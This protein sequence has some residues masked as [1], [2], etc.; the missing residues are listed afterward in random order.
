MTS[1]LHIARPYAMAAFSYARDKQQLPAWKAF[2]A[3]AAI[4]SKDTRVV[5]WLTQP[6]RLK[7][8]LYDL[9][10][11]VLTSIINHEQRNFLLLL[12]EH[13][14][15]FILQE[16]ADLFHT[17]CASYEKMHSV[18]VIT[19]IFIEK[20]MQQLFSHHLSKRL[21]H[22]VTLQCEVDPTILGG[23]IIHIGD[24]VIDGSIRGKLYRLLE[25]SLRS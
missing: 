23:A 22:E 13:N 12:S 17:Y 4:I 7:N 2:L 11:H 10:Q 19:A 3:S 21:M 9:F 24:H 16:I 5:Q 25:F 15:F 1:V 20:K 6:K 14:R 18:R 8:Q